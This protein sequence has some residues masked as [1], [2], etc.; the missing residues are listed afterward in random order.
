MGGNVIGRERELE[1]LRAFLD[2]RGDSPQLLVLEGPAGIGKST[3]L[4]AALAEATAARVLSARPT[5]AERDLPYVGLLD[6]LEPALGEVLPAL[7]P[8]RRRALEAALLFADSPEEPVDGRAVGLGVRDALH[9]LVRCEPVLVAVDD[10]PW[11]DQSSADALAVALHRISGPLRVLLTRRSSEPVTALEQSL[12]A[13]TPLVMGPMSLGALHRVLHDRLGRSFSRP[14]LL[15]LHELSGGNPLYA[16]ELAQSAEPETDPLR[17]LAVPSSLEALFRSRL[18]AL[19]PATRAALELLSV[20][21]APSLGLMERAGVT[22]DELAPA[23]SARVVDYERSALRFTHPIFAAV[24]YE[25]LALRRPALHRR[26]ANLAADPLSRARHLALATELPDSSV[27]EQ[28]EAAAE[29]A[30][31]RAALALAAELLEHAL[32]L[33]LLGDEAR[34]RRALRTAKAQLAAGEW[35]RARA[36]LEGLRETVSAGPLRAE[37]LLALAET[38]HDD[39]AV[40][41]LQ[42]AQREAA[43]DRDIRARVAL[44]LAWAER[45]RAGFPHALEGTLSALQL[46]ENDDL[47][48]RVDGLGQLVALASVVG[49]VRLPTYRAEAQRLAAQVAEPRLRAELTAVSVGRATEANEL[50]LRSLAFHG[51]LQHWQERDELLAA[52]LL[53]EL[54]WV[55]LWGGRWELAWSHAEQS[56]DVVVQYGVEKNQ[57]YI[58]TAWIAAH[59]GRV[60]VALAEAERGLVLSDEQIGFRPPLLQAAPGLVALWGGDAAAALPYLEKADAV[61]RTLGWSAAGARPWTPDLVQ[62]L[63]EVGRTGE[64]ASVLQV[65][66]SDASRVSDD[67]S[68]ARARSSRGLL[69]AAEGRLGESAEEFRCA[70]ERLD[71]V[72]DVFGRARAQLVLGRVLRRERKKKASRDALQNALQAFELLGASVWAARTTSE[73]GSIGGRTRE[74]GLTPAERRVADLAAAGRTNREV[75]AELVLGERTVEGH[76][77]RVYAK[78]GVRSR[79]ELARLLR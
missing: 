67:W 48:L 17:P 53:W 65:W 69:L 55:E 2:V 20:L 30:T 31:G 1:Q 39:L 72:D 7:P 64:A 74:H 21:G 11:L 26:A 32:R 54:S 45:F 47:A 35:Q 79:T 77:S 66:E 75:A 56:R 70:V 22:A 50:H 57:D 37:V 10:V 13:A 36:L 41:L 27:A 62:S 73:L 6:L 25:D 4:A 63:A 44:D 24:V 51:L 46:L 52:E 61:A 33:T 43:S 5:E 16:L 60:D 76:L 9:E 18:N 34:S 8:P 12:G 68:L 78:L 59:L 71:A 58:A 38:E 29:L 3:L 19:P 42:E 15:R 49:D 40:P 28:L 14:T 23:V